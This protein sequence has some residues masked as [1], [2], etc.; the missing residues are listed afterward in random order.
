M[1]KDALAYIKVNGQEKAFAEINNPRGRF[2]DRDLYITVVDM[3]GK[4]LAHGAIPELI[5][6]NRIESKDSDGKFFIK[7]RIEMA[8]TKGSGW[9]DYKFTDPLT[10]KVEPK[11]FYLEK[12]GD[13]IVG[14]GVYKPKK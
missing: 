7:E 3:N 4:I 1:V 11:K 10:K 12:Y 8:K 6:T 5:G 14:C 13:I 9:Q 2:V